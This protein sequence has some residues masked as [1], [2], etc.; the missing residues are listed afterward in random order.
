MR[1]LITTDTVGGVWTFT[2][3]LATDLLLRGHHVALVSLGGMPSESQRRWCDETA[4]TWAPGFLYVPSDAPLEWMQDNDLAY[5]AALPAL[6]AC[7]GSFEPEIVLSSQYCFGKL[8]IGIPKIIVAHSDV[9]SWSQACGKY[10][11][12]SSAW[13]TTYVR[14]VSEGLEQAEAVVAPTHWMLSALEE[15]FTVPQHAIVIL[16]GRSLQH[17]GSVAAKSFQAVTAGR[18]WDEAKNISILNHFESPVPIVVVGSY[19]HG[20]NTATLDSPSVT[21]AGELSEAEILSVF[22]ESSIYIC[23][24]IYEPFGLAPLEAALCGCAVVANNIP[25]LHEVWAD[26][27]L[28]F[29]DSTSLKSILEQLRDR[30]TLS[31]AQTRS[32]ERAE[33]FTSSR[34]TE[35]YLNLFERLLR[36]SVA[37]GSA[38]AA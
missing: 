38:H 12:P 37:G 11:L 17:S 4:A 29:D 15:H 3:Q 28:F 1:V 21:L 5:S 34:M 33:I 10:P 18:F 7:I 14:L 13:L 35:R 27:A 9:L 36:S 24:S 22:R 19:V 31:R 30:D 25:S 26:C 20:S 32:G 2:R 23:T 6:L 16:N 8:P